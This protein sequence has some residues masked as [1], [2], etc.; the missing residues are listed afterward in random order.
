MDVTF[1]C[2]KCDGMATARTCPHGEAERVQI[3][4]TEQRA[5]L[6]TGAPVPPQF[7]RPE[8]VAILRAYYADADEQSH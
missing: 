6:A 2:R 4:G 3:S 8:V 7:S 1:F 5:L